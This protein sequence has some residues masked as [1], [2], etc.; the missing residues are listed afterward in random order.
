MKTDSRPHTL[1]DA[2]LEGATHDRQSVT[3]Q[4]EQTNQQLIAGVRI[5]EIRPVLKRDG[6]LTEVFR[7]DWFDEPLPVDQVFQA[8]LSPGH[9]SAWHAHLKTTDRLFVTAGSI[10]LALYD[11]RPDSLTARLVNELQ[12][13]IAR[14]RLVVV[15]PGVWHGLL[16]T[17]STPAIVLNLPDAAYCYADPDHW[18]LPADTP[19]IPYR[20]K[21]GAAVD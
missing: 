11:A 19:Q 7:R 9:V 2:I 16:V 6:A 12:L 13:G 18:R 20:F 17:G 10:T 5:I 3:P 1:T 8:A 14:P 15:P 21:I 4:W